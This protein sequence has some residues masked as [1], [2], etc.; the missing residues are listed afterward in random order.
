MKSFQEY[1]NEEIFYWYIIKGDLAKGKIVYAGNEKQV[2]K[3]RHD[4]RFGDGHVMTKSRKMKKVGDKWKKAEGVSE[5]WQHDPL[6]EDTKMGKQT[7]DNL[8]KI[9]KKAMA[10]DQSSPANKFMTKRIS[11][12]MKKRGIKEDSRNKSKPDP[13]G[14]K[15]PE[16][17][18]DS[19]KA[20]DLLKKKGIPA[21]YD[22]SMYFGD[23]IYVQRDNEEKAKKIIPKDL[24]QYVFGTIDNPVQ[25]GFRTTQ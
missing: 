8:R 5:E 7:D 19:L 4:P 23:R 2:K 25:A 21:K 14:R 6:G 1:L 9:Y 22:N 10:A 18:K 24:H 15:H 3:K 13:K 16:I 20:I 17:K 12:E 11:K